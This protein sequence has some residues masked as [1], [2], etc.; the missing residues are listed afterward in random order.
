MYNIRKRPASER[1]IVTVMAQGRH[2]NCKECGVMAEKAYHRIRSGG[3][4]QR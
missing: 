3:R 1:V 4:P 2:R